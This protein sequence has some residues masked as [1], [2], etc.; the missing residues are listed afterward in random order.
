[1]KYIDFHEFI[2]IIQFHFNSIHISNIAPVAALEAIETTVR[3]AVEEAMKAA[4]SAAGTLRIIYDYL[5]P[6]GY[7]NTIKSK[8]F[9]STTFF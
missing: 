6:A 7:A 4:T 2:L 8:P 1:L 5:T 3:A 9:S